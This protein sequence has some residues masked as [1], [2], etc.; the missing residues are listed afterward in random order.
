MIHVNDEAVGADQESRTDAR[1]LTRRRRA[2]APAVPLWITKAANVSA[3]LV[4]LCLGRF[5]PSHV[6]ASLDISRDP[7]LQTPLGMAIESVVLIWCFWSSGSDRGRSRSRP[8]A[9]QNA[10][11]IDLR[12]TDLGRAT[13]AWAAQFALMTAVWLLLLKF[14]P[15][16]PLAVFRSLMLFALFDRT[17][18][19][20]RPRGAPSP[21]LDAN[22]LAVLGNLLVYLVL[23]ATTLWLWW[24]QDGAAQDG[25]G[26]TELLIFPAIVMVWSGC[27]FRRQPPEVG[28]APGADTRLFSPAVARLAN[29]AIFL[30][31]VGPLVAVAWFGCGPVCAIVSLVL[32]GLLAA[33]LMKG[34]GLYFRSG[35]SEEVFNRLPQTKH[36]AELKQ[37]QGKTGNTGDGR[38]DL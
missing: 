13:V 17:I 34:C 16:D 8:E 5:W 29:A 36:D 22:W 4:L 7:F 25:T 20:R 35:V 33:W 27:Y 18:W 37:L 23:F 11:A 21:T 30:G 3:V 2:R 32:W 38:D 12:L 10:D 9:D 15:R 28:E 19:V 26:F 14:I 6:P 24:P 1:A 31:L